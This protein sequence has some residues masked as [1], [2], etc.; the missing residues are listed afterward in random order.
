MDHFDRDRMWLIVTGSGRC[1][2]GYVAH[3][4]SSC[5]VNCTHEKVFGL[6]GL[7]WAREQIRLRA[8]NPDWG[9]QADASW[10]A[11]PFL[12][13]P[14]VGGMKII[15]L[16]R[17]PR[18]VIRSLQRIRNWT[19]LRY[20]PGHDF[21]YEHMP[22]LLDYDDLNERSAYF[23]CEWNRR[24]EV[25][26]DFLHR[27][28]DD[29]CIVLDAADINWESYWLFDNTHYNTRAFVREQ[30]FELEDLPPGLLA[31]VRDSMSRYGYKEGGHEMTRYEMREKGLIG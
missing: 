1:G 8:E 16:V 28:E 13:D 6:D 27:V 20:K 26:A 14:C 25:H 29:V 9:W 7:D 22:E 24:I 18:N 15:H 19:A 21:L 5:G 10:M 30:P 4:L 23:W 2:T 12:D 11:M 17:H 31:M 3:V